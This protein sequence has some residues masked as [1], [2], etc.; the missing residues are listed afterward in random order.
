MVRHEIV[1]GTAVISAVAAGA[2]VG[3]GV[4]AVAR[5]EIGGA[6]GISRA[7]ARIGRTVG[8]GMLAGV[9]VIAAAATLGGLIVYTGLTQVEELASSY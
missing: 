8:G 3:M 7:L 5:G 1:A 6:P 2:G 4:V 9:G